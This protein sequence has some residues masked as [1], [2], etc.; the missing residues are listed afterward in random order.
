[1]EYTVLFFDLTCIYFNQSILSEWRKVG[2]KIVLQNIL[3]VY[4]YKF[5]NVN[6]A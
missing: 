3:N 2:R 1:M 6:I 4:V 5:L